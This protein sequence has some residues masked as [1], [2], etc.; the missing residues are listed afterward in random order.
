[1][2]GSLDWFAFCSLDNI[3]NFVE[4]YGWEEIAE[5]GIGV[6]FIGVESKFADLLKYK[7]RSKIDP[8]LVFHPILE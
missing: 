3:G 5:M 8:K 6:M 7:K 4:K 2:V 1:M